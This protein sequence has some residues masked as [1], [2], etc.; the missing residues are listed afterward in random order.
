MSSRVA[1]TC[2]RVSHRWAFLKGFLRALRLVQLL[3]VCDGA[4]RR[5]LA[6]SKSIYSQ[7]W[8]SSSNLKAFF[9]KKNISERLWENSFKGRMCFVNLPTDFLASSLSLRHWL[10]SKQISKLWYWRTK[11]YT[12]VAIQVQ[13][14]L[15]KPKKLRNIRLFSSN[16][17]LK[18]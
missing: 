3:R 1:R 12:N 14:F 16:K 9:L 17:K 13:A 15:R 5:K 6:K 7:Q 2:V 18:A 10:A 8:K 11:K 4:N